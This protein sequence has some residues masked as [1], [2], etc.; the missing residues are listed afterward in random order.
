MGNDCRREIFTCM[1]NFEIN[2]K[3]WKF[4]YYITI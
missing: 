1:E 2:I 3:K 4:F